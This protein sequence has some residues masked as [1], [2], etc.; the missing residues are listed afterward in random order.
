M[1]FANIMS[2]SDHCSRS[3]EQR[4]RFGVQ[5]REREGACLRQAALLAW[6]TRPLEDVPGS[7][8]MSTQHC[9]SEQDPHRSLVQP[10]LGSDATSSSSYIHG[11]KGER[12]GPTGLSLDGRDAVQET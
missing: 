3:L 7:C 1:Y 4:R 6:G 8:D 2:P 11:G 9:S 5:W 10:G 12:R